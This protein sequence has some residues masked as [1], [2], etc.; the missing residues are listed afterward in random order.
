[1]MTNTMWILF[2]LVT[3]IFLFILSSC[4]KYNFNGYRFLDWTFLLLLIAFKMSLHF[5]SRPLLFLMAR[6]KTFLPYLSSMS[7]AFVWFFWTIWNIEIENNFS[8]ISEILKF[9]TISKTFC[10]DV[11]EIVWIFLLVCFFIVFFKY[12]QIFNYF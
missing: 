6:L 9:K 10:L 8:G 1:M 12:G 3:K 5:F 4:L 7:L 2:A 11:I